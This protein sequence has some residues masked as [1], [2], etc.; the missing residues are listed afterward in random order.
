VSAPA[1]ISQ[2]DMERAVKAAARAERARV[3]FRLDRGEIEVIIGESLAD[4]PT[5]DGWSDDDV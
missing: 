4:T 5:D 2:A 3:I 1:R